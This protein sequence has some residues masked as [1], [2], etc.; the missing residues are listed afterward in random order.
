M[1]SYGMGIMLLQQGFLTK[2]WLQTRSV[3]VLEQPVCT[4]D[5]SPNENVYHIMMNK[6]LTIEQLKTWIK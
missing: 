6:T 2:Q 3:C 1:F 5:L 4:L